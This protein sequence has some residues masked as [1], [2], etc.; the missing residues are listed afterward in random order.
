MK[1][2]FINYHCKY[3]IEFG[4]QKMI[5]ELKELKLNKKIFYNKKFYRLQ[6]L[7]YLYKKKLVDDF[8]KWK[9]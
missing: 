3:T 6:Y 8:L 4:I 2:T 1:K 7:E 5:K 9:I